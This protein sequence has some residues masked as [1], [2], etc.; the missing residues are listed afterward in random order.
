MTKKTIEELKRERDE[1]KKTVDEL[2]ARERLEK[3]LAA[4]KLEKRKRSLLGKTVRALKE[5]LKD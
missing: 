1:L 4:L 5:A 2:K 3:E